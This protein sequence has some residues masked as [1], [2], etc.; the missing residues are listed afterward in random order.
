MLASASTSFPAFPACSQC[1]GPFRREEDEGTLR[2]CLNPLTG[3]LFYKYTCS[4]CSLTGEA[5]FERLPLSWINVI[6]LVLFHLHQ[7]DRQRV[8]FFRWK[9]DICQLIEERWE[10]LLPLKSKTASWMNSVS[11]VLSANSSI[12][13]S[14]FEKLKQ[15][16]WW[17]LRTVQPP[18]PPAYAGDGNGTGEGRRRKRRADEFEELPTTGP[19]NEE[20]KRAE[21]SIPRPASAHTPLLA[22]QLRSPL[23]ADTAQTLL[24]AKHYVDRI[25]NVSALLPLEQEATPTTVR[26]AQEIKRK[27]VERLLRV[28]SKLLQE[29]LVNAPPSGRF[30]GAPMSANT[31]IS[32]AA[33]ASLARPLSTPPMASVALSP[34]TN[35]SIS[36]AHP[37]LAPQRS[38]APSTLQGT[39]DSKEVRGSKIGGLPTR[40]ELKRLQKMARPANYVRASPH[41]NELLEMSLRVINSDSTLSRFKRKLIM[42][43][44]KRRAGLA[45]FDLDQII[46]R[47]LK[48]SEP[49]LLQESEHEE[50][51]SEA[52]L[53]PTVETKGETRTYYDV[54]YVRDPTL[55]FKAK[56]LG[57]A[58]VKGYPFD[59]ISPFSGL[60]LPAYIHRESGIRPLK[61]RLF[62]EMREKG[63]LKE[64]EGNN[65]NELDLSNT[66]DFIHVRK[67]FIPQVNR[68]LRKFFWPSIDMAESLDYPDYGVVVL[69]RKLVIG[70]AFM[71]PD[72]YVTYL[73]IHPEWADAGL[74]S[75]LLH[76]LITRAS[77]SHLDITLHVSATNPAML[78]YQKFGFKPEE[79][80]VNFYDKYYRDDE[81]TVGQMALHSK[82]AFLIRLRR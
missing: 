47:Y 35:G 61:L 48:S 40:K 39:N 10:T 64:D 71:T 70:C 51:C 18:R 3:D 27:L 60:R 5:T 26:A 53:L 82:N 21:L 73:L 2:K 17:A 49:L 7:T 50:G 6:R 75:I 16:G 43:R 79:Y 24:L 28:D 33:V 54:P 42:R 65:A 57:V 72:S 63:Y 67:E 76:L 12:F 25:P 31:N 68:L 15:P 56:L 74:G 8:G 46:Y 66:I 34:L 41:E 32:F 4:R 37:V 30:E 14:G 20:E 1:Q 38:V 11:S 58:N 62:D 23:S 45:I 69:Y 9:E 22:T 81:D 44:A 36:S 59:R 13:I 55:S 29:A 77:P 78:L 52:T 19:S 80:I